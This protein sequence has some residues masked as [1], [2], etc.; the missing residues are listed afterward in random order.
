MASPWVNDLVIDNGPAYIK[1]NCNSMRLVKTY[2]A[3]DSYATVHGNSIAAVAMASG[4]FTIG[5]GDPNGRTLT[6]AVK[7]NVSA[8]ADSGATPDLVIAFVN[9]TGTAVL[10]VTNETSDQ[11][12]V[13]GNTVDFPACTLHLPQVTAV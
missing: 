10:W 8:T 4:D 7:S 2:S 3:A 11:V 6:T 5:A 13:N 1:A 12:V 9:T